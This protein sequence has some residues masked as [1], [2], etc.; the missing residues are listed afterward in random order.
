MNYVDLDLLDYQY[1]LEDMRE[2]VQTILKAIESELRVCEMR[3]GIIDEKTK[4]S[5]A[6]KAEVELC[7]CFNSLAKI[8]IDTGDISP[9]CFEPRLPNIDQQVSL[10][11]FDEMI[12]VK[13]PYLRRS[14]NP[15]NG[16]KLAFYDL[17]RT[18]IYGVDESAFAG[19]TLV[20]YIL[21]IYPESTTKRSVIDADNINPKI[22]GDPIT[23]QLGVDDNAE[24]VLLAVYAIRTD[25]LPPASYSVFTPQ[26]S[27]LGPQELLT[28]LISMFSGKEGL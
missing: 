23:Q 19:R 16:S 1:Q 12:V 26:G 7:K 17:L 25:T 22:V 10:W 8:D 5:F 4:F 21:S 18:L 11:Q 9:E 24:D 15:R 14:Y 27:V 13:T 6:R 3:Q 2:A 20:H 28:L